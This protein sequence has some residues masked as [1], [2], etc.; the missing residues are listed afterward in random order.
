MSS[1][2]NFLIRDLDL[3]EQINEKKKAKGVRDKRGKDGRENEKK[4]RV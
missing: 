2:E 1:G 4:K 3:K